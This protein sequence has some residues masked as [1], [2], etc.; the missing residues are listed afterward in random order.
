[1]I[2]E[3]IDSATGCIIG[4]VLHEMGTYIFLFQPFFFPTLFQLTGILVALYFLFTAKYHKIQGSIAPIFDF[5]CLWTI[6][7]IIRG[8]LMGN[9]PLGYAL[10]MSSIIDYTI[11]NPYSW[12]AFVMPLIARVDFNPNSLLFLKKI[13]IALALVCLVSAFLSRN[14]VFMGS[15]NGRTNIVGLDGEYLLVRILITRL[16]PCF[17]LVVFLS[18]YSNYIKSRFKAIVPLTIVA[19][20]LGM[21]IGGGR[22]DSVIAFGYLITFFY[23]SYKY[24][25]SLMPFSK[26][27]DSKWQKRALIVFLVFVFAYSMVYLVNNTTTFDFLFFRL[28]DNGKGGELADF[29]RDGITIQFIQDF[30]NHPLDWIF[31]RGVNGS[32][33]CT[34]RDI[35]IN[36]RRAAMEWGYLY[37]ILKGGIVYLILGAVLFLHAIWQGF[38][39]SNN[40]FSKACACMCLWQVINLVSTRSEPKFA[41]FFVLS[42]LCFGFL[43]NKSFRTLKDSDFLGYF[44]VKGYP[45]K[46]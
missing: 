39:R 1:M 26:K 6:I 41:L 36:G 21:I 15:I 24:Q 43:E 27:R 44:N 16:F 32:Y 2:R 11:K 29:N 31:G 34:E 40:L 38:F 12:I 20:M 13:G 7:M 18:F 4:V 33:V 46:K 42:W 28:F 10:S 3:K 37:M 5:F 25:V 22:S 35:N 45:G 14:D 23:L 30:N 9:A 19:Y 8:S 17:G